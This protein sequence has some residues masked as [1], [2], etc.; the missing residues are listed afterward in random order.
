MIRSW[1]FGSMLAAVFLAAGCEKGGPGPSDEEL[2]GRELSP[3]ETAALDE[4]RDELDAMAAEARR[5]DAEIERQ[6]R[7]NEKLKREVETD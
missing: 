4:I 5:L 6:R 7:E 2:I 3:E 1:L